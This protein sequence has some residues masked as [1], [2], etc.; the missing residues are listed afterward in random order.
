MQVTETIF[1]QYE[2]VRESGRTNMVDRIAVQRIAEELGH[3][4]LV[5]FIRSGSY[6]DLLENYDEHAAA[7]QSKA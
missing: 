7:Y 3:D 1:K 5:E 2:E 6:Y 4:E